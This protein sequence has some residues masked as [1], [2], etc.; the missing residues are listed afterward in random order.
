MTSN[1]FKHSPGLYF[2]NSPT[3]VSEDLINFLLAELVLD[4]LPMGRI[5]LHESNT[6]PLH[7][8][9]IAVR[10]LHIYPPHQHIWKHEFYTILKGICLFKTFN[11][12]GLEQSFLELQECSSYL[13]STEDFHTLVPLTDPLVFLETTV[14]PYTG[15]QLT[16][17]DASC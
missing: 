14:G 3:V 8:M 4:N 11:K 1:P 13:N 2:L 6:S 5:C 9:L 10:S 16:Y 17:L 7:S 12:Q 15:R